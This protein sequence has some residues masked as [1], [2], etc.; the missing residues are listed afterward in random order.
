ME[1]IFPRSSKHQW[2]TWGH[3]WL[4]PNFS[5]ASRHDDPRGPAIITFHPFCS[6]WLCLFSVLSPLSAPNQLTTTT[7]HT[8]RNGSWV[9]AVPTPSGTE[10]T[11]PGSGDLT[12]RHG[13]I[14]LYWLGMYWAA[15]NIQPNWHSLN[16]W[17]L[18]CLA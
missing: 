13:G 6:L 18:I 1:F 5:P 16:K 17:V 9:P 7:T 2:P 15:S 14:G 12:T 11:G 4:S 3:T 10:S 8:L